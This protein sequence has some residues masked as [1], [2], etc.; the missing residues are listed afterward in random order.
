M[1]AR[2]LVVDDQAANVRLLEARL[3]AEYF[4][5]CTATNGY[6]AIEAARLEQPDLILL[7]VMMPGMDGYET[8]ERLKADNSTRHIP[9]V[10]VTALDQRED[11]IRGLEAGADDFLTKPIDD[12]ALFARVR[13]L[14][15]L[16]AVLD[17]LRYR[18]ASSAIAEL[19]ADFADDLAEISTAIIVSADPRAGA[20]YAS[21]LPEQVRAQVVTDPVEALAGMRKGTDL[22]IVDLTHPEFDGLRLCARVRSDAATRPLP[23]L[24]V[25]SPDDT[26]Q[27][28][29]ALDLG[30]NDIIH[31]PVDAGELNARVRTQL[32]RKRYAD[33]LRSQL[34]QS[35]EMAVTDPL[36]GLHN[37]RYINSRLRQAL[38]SADNGGAPVSVL[39]ADID[40]F[41]SINDLYGHEAGD[42]VLRGFADR[43]QK[44]MRALDLASRYGGEEFLVLMPAAGLAEARIAAE[45]LRSVV[46]DAPFLLEDGTD[47]AVTVSVGLAQAL[48][49][50][51]VEAVLR[52][53]DQA[54]YTAKNEGR[55]QVQVAS[56]A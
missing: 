29:R 47:I 15:R 32:R 37:R 3:Q 43:V 41:K 39:I 44:A 1:S 21:A 5:V 2:I 8:C 24:T 18:E 42:T 30:V 28:V 45:R 17:E 14:L 35:L 12:V 22:L 56:A 4:D 52:R 50:E 54:L 53:A 51:G 16:K 26:A 38:A 7:D 34:D 27:A 10:M 36:T 48:P 9:V 33:R 23:I 40:H 13:S 31:R 11:R 6:E 25:V 19:Q 46:A 49:G 55:N 20:R